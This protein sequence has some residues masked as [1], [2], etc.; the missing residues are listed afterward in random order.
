MWYISSTPSNSAVSRKPLSPIVFWAWYTTG[1][2]FLVPGVHWISRLIIRHFGEFGYLEIGEVP[3]RGML[4]N[5]SKF[6]WEIIDDLA[7]GRL[8]PLSLQH[9]TSCDYFASYR[10]SNGRKKRYGVLFTRL[11]AL[12]AHV[13]ISAECT[14][15]EFLQVLW[16]FERFTSL[17]DMQQWFSIGWRWARVTRN[18][19][20][21][22]WQRRWTEVPVKD[23]IRSL[24]PRKQWNSDK[25]IVRVDDLAIVQTQ[26]TV[27]K[28]W[29]IGRADGVSMRNNIIAWHWFSEIVLFFLFKKNYSG[30]LY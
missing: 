19:W 10:I 4:R 14:T 12:A 8:S 1:S 25:Q 30:R 3:M 23:I 17:N 24:L 16:R 18:D 26:G 20:G 11:N 13:K 7:Q 9:N 21:F 27:C 15:M 6:E 28:N 22:V 2:R 5:W 29:N